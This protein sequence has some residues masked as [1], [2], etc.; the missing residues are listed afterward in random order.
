[1]NATTAERYSR[2]E[3]STCLVGKNINRKE[4]MHMP[5]P[6]WAKGLGKKG[7]KKGGGGGG[8]GG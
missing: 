4:V 8:G 3:T 7:G 6:T 1:M 2:F 5:T